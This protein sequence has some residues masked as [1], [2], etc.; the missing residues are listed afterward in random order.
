M[1]LNYDD[2]IV[3]PTDEIVTAIMDLLREEHWRYH[4]PPPHRYPFPTPM[5]LSKPS[6]FR[7]RLIKDMYHIVH[8]IMEETAKNIHKGG[9]K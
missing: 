4:G 7:K 5:W 1:T 9:K 6:K 2:H 8:D 3:D